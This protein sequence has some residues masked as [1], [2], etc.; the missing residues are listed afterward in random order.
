MTSFDVVAYLRGLLNE[1]KIGHAGTLDPAAAGVLP[2]CI[3][4]A[5]KCI[6][7]IMDMKKVYRAELTLGVSTDTQDSSGNIIAVKDVLASEQQILSTIKNFIGEI[8]QTPPMYSAIKVDGKRLYELAR[9]GKSIERKPRKV[10]IHS[11]DVIICDRDK[12]LFDVTCSKGTY[13]RTLCSDIG[14]NLGCGGHM[15]FLIRTR[16]GIFDIQS[17]LTLEEILKEN[18]YGK[19]YG[20]FL[21]VDE[22]FKKHKGFRLDKDSEEKFKNGRYIYINCLNDLNYKNYFNNIDDIDHLNDGLLVRVYGEDNSFIALGKVIK[23]E[24][25]LYLKPEK[26]FI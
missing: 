20:M 19:I 13:I 9:E 17:A 14:D 15:S 8:Y 16:T 22:V 12:V 5:T 26:M 2:I 24:E 1:K 23:I 7:Y 11:I 21:N 4:K 6:E 3:G 18:S 10:L 25:K